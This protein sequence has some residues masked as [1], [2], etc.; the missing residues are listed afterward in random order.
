[1]KAKAPGGEGFAQRRPHLLTADGRHVHGV[2]PEA[3]R[4]AGRRQGGALDSAD[5]LLARSAGRLCAR[6]TRNVIGATRTRD[7]NGLL[8]DP[9]G[10]CTE[11]PVAAAK[12]QEL[13]QG[14][15]RWAEIGELYKTVAYFAPSRNDQMTEEIN[16]PAPDDPCDVYHHS[17]AIREVS[18]CPFASS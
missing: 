1:M 8:A 3:F 18:A 10:A 5:T 11:R 12:V 14:N 7:G 6:C 2:K 13:S 15:A 4:A 16:S 9:F 17:N